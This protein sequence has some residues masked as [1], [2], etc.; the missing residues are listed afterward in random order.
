MGAA[1][2]FDRCLGLAK[3]SEPLLVFH[4]L[5]LSMDSDRLQNRI[6]D[7]SRDLVTPAE[8][9]NLLLDAVDLVAETAQGVG[10]SLLEQSKKGLNRLGKDFVGVDVFTDSDIDRRSA[11]SNEDD[12]RATGSTARKVG[13]SIGKEFLPLLA[14]GLLPAKPFTAFW[15][16]EGRR[17]GEAVIGSKT[18]AVLGNRAEAVFGA[19]A[20]TIIGSKTE[21]A[22]GARAEPVLYHGHYDFD[23]LKA[24]ESKLSTRMATKQFDEP[25]G[26]INGRWESSQLIESS[27][28]RQLKDDI[29][30]VL[31]GQV[32]G[33][34]DTKYNAIRFYTDTTATTNF[35]LDEKLMVK[36]VSTAEGTLGGN[37]SALGQSGILE[38]R[39][40]ERLGISSELRSGFEKSKQWSDSLLNKLQANDVYSLPNVG[41]YAGNR[42]DTALVMQG[43]AIVAD[44]QS[45]TS[46]KGLHTFG[47]GPCSILMLSS[48]CS[49]GDLVKIALAHIDAKS[50]SRDVS[51][52]IN[53]LGKGANIEATVISGERN[54]SLEIGKALES[55]GTKLKFSDIDITQSRADAAVI[56]R[57]GKV[58]YGT[59]PDLM[60][61]MD[62]ASASALTAKVM[63]PF[64]VPLSIKNI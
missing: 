14:V 8:R 38:V 47:A 22:I 52:L 29:S 9:S 6:D 53:S 41:S 31:P 43:E 15:G 4:T 12:V 26:Q 24:A 27:I 56:D 7:S 37:L 63:D 17:L 25:F 44:L 36:Q 58:Y 32:R 59:K 57:T 45:N 48:R 23:A 42:S 11:H 20:E 34:R 1:S 28:L 10:K 46:I 39:A 60:P 13:E 16:T 51:W 2:R 40:F 55:S 18:E 21:S 19:R 35:W 33:Y 54:L 61:Q 3:Q 50:T 62:S 5:G 30:V 64:R 49:N